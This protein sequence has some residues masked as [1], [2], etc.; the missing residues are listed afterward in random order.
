MQGER[1]IRE[2]KI[3][4]YAK[5]KNDAEEKA[6]NLCKI[7]LGLPLGEYIEVLGLERMTAKKKVQERESNDS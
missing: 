6:K 1:I 5:N 2:A 3:T 4:I 7:G